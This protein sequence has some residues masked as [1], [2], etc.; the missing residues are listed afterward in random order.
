MDSQTLAAPI[1]GGQWSSIEPA[2]AGGCRLSLPAAG[3]CKLSLPESAMP[4]CDFQK[5]SGNPQN[6]GSP[7]YAS[8]IRRENA[9]QQVTVDTADVGNADL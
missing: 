7:I 9:R 5:I 8:W 1:Y 6:S 3:G 2:A 4:T